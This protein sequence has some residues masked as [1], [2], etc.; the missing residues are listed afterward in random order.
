VEE[1]RFSA[2]SAVT[3][4]SR[5][6]A[7]VEAPGFSATVEELPLR[8]ASRVK[9][10]LSSLCRA[11]GG[12]SVAGLKPGSSTELTNPGSSVEERRFSAASASKKHSAL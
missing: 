8:A 4:D 11:T 12:I 3:K 6:F 10:R 2:A 5:A 7:L 9:K 1:R